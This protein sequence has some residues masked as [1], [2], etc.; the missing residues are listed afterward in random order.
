[1]LVGCEHPGGERAL[2]QVH[3]LMSSTI[4]ENWDPFS[5]KSGNEDILLDWQNSRKELSVVIYFSWETAM[6]RG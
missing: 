1:M 2:L 3:V 4:R 5:D 6:A